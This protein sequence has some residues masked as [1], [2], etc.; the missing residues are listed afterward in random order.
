MGNG[1]RDVDSRQEQDGRNR[2]KGGGIEMMKNGW[3]KDRGHREIMGR[4]PG[5]AAKVAH[6]THR[7]QELE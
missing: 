7:E 4:L 2:M 5:A 1:Q 3:G 6:N